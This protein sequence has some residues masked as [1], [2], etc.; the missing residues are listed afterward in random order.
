MTAQPLT[1]RDTHSMLLG[2]LL[3]LFGFLGAHRF[4][5]GKPVTGT[6]WFFTLGLLGIGWLIDLFLIPAMD[7][8]ADLRFT[9]GPINYSLAWLLLTFLGVF[10]L[11][12]FYQGKWLSG[13]VYLLT[14]GLFGLGV[15]YDFW[16]LNDQI[17]MRHARRAE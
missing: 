7:R 13:I 11:H 9:S 3:W 10:G 4:Y 14:F 17:S 12:R 5:Y 6:I 1:S 15:L 2:Y 8:Q 16:T